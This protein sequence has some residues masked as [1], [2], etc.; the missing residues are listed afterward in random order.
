M[1]EITL[2]FWAFSVIKFLYHTNLLTSDMFF[3]E[4]FDADY[5]LSNDFFWLNYFPFDFDLIA[6]PGTHSPTN[7]LRTLFNAITKWNLR[8]EKKKNIGSLL[9]ALHT[10]FLIVRVLVH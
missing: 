4:F 7:R 8:K 9:G 5:A 1:I 3:Q 10:F 2:I 6:S